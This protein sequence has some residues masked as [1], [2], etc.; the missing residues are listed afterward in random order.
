MQTNGALIC[1]GDVICFIQKTVAVLVAH[2]PQD[3]EWVA[4]VPF[5][6]PFQSIK[7]SA[8]AFIV[9][10]N[11]VMYLS[12][13]LQDFTHDKVIGIL[14]ACVGFSL[15]DIAATNMANGKGSLEILSVNSWCMS[16]QVAERFTDQGSTIK[17]ATTTAS[18]RGGG[19]KDCSVFLIGD[20]AH[21]F[22]PAGG[23]GM[24]TGIQD[25]HNL[26]WKLA[27]VCNESASAGLLE[28]YDTG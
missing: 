9:A 27:L 20:A 18:S 25:A 2:A 21:R 13:L 10:T 1:C 19:S 6:P 22:P 5:F 7:V 26:A 24:N 11:A 23:F 4:Q 3:D 15:K 8:H 28:T 12:T 16:A 14:E 17:A